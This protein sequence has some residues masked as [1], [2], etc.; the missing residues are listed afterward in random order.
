MPPTS[1]AAASFTTDSLA[2]ASISPRCGSLA[3]TL[4]TPKSTAKA[5][6]A[7]ATISVV[8]PGQP[9]DGALGGVARERL[10]ADGDRLELQREIGQQPDHRR[11]AVTSTASA[12][13]LP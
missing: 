7:A 10:E 8:P 6:I 1:I 11:V 9:A 5:A 3:L 13:L 2:T 4:R 12:R